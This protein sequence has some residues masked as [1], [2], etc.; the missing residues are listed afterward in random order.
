MNPTSS[1]DA[2]LFDLDG[3]LTSTA[4]LHATAWKRTFDAMLAPWGQ[5]PFDLE[6]DYLDHVDGKPRADGVRDF[7]ASRGITLDD[8]S[9]Q[10]IA[11]RKQR[12]FDHVLDH[13]GV[14]AF[15]GSVRWVRHLRA[16]GLSTAVVS[17]SANTDRVLRAAEITA[18][19]DLTID[20]HDVRELGLRG[21]PA[22]DGFLE[23]ARRLDVSPARA[24]V[25][26]DAL[27]G[28]AAG[29]AGAFG[30]VIGVSRG[31]GAC[32]LRAAGADVVVADLEELV[33]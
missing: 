24:V 28:V 8:A 23:A 20:A 17:S 29:R 22:P 16:L 14:E 6:R 33:P 2:V 13:S 25:V 5:E 27:V 11:G 4:A 1:F 18:L 3:V 9:V 31:A 32:E 21:K 30:L 10:T 15:P 19:F 7:L 26:E 12:H